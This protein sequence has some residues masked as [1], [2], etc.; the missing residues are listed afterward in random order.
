MLVQARITGGMLELVDTEG[1]CFNTGFLM[2]E[3]MLKRYESTLNKDL[4]K[5]AIK[6]KESGFTADEIIE[7]KKEGIL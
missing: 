4:V 7:M 5:K 6:L 1:I 3:D 2:N